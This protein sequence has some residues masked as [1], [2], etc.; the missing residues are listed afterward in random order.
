MVGSFPDGPAPDGAAAARRG[1]NVM[2]GAVP[3]V[4]R[5]GASC[6][7]ASVRLRVTPCR[8]RRRREW[9]SASLGAKIAC[10]GPFSPI[11][12]AVMMSAPS[13]SHACAVAVLHAWT[14]RSSARVPLGSVP[15]TST[16]AG[17]RSAHAYTSA[18][19]ARAAHV[20]AP[21]HRAMLRATM[22]RILVRRRDSWRWRSICAIIVASHPPPPCPRSPSCWSLSSAPRPPWPSPPVPRSSPL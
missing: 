16:F 7:I 2:A 15:S 5:T 20:A 13:P 21:C 9:A 14:A 22:L 19:V 11:L 10:H 17:A 18:I 4:C 8:T 1:M 12:V 3:T 6:A